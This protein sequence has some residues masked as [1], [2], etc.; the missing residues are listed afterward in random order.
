[1]KEF[2][3]RWIENEDEG[4]WRWQWFDCKIGKESRGDG[5]WFDGS[6]CWSKGGIQPF[7]SASKESVASLVVLKEKTLLVTK[8][9]MLRS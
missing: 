6:E 9:Q 1:M 3:W 2:K 8:V 5:K 7:G 4:N